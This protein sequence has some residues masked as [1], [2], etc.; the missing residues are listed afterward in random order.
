M[1]RQ[2]SPETNAVVECARAF[3]RPS[4][5]ASLR[6]ALALPLDWD[7]LERIADDHSVMPLVAYVVGRDA[8]DV[9]PTHILRRFRERFIR[10]TQNNLAGAQE[11]QRRT[12]SAARSGRPGNFLQRT[13]AGLDG[14]WESRLARVP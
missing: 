8:G 13:G 3:L 5:G 4:E 7:A 14:L 1:K 10:I 11:W 2:M 12:A 6:A 9:V